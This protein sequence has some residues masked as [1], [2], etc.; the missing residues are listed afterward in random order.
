[1]DQLCNKFNNHIPMETT[2]HF[3]TDTFRETII[4]ENFLASELNLNKMWH[5]D[6]D[7]GLIID[8]VYKADDYT[9]LYKFVNTDQDPFKSF[10]KSSICFET[11]KIAM[12]DCLL[13]RWRFEMSLLKE[14]Y[15]HLF[16]SENVNRM[17]CIVNGFRKIPIHYLK[18]V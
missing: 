2:L 10:G 15:E 4:M 12:D 6:V 18:S 5:L 13:N 8:A 17:F 7:V 1:M 16:P 3:S 11:T 14:K 9:E